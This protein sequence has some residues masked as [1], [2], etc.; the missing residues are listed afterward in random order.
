M[1]ICFLFLLRSEIAVAVVV[2]VDD[3]ALNYNFWVNQYEF[4][5]V[6]ARSDIPEI[7]LEPADVIED[8]IATEHLSSVPP[9]A[10]Q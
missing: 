2:G 8:F 10:E 4:Q 9:T 5:L 1:V 7:H 6:L 3:D